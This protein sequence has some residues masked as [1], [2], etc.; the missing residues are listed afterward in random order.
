MTYGYEDP[1]IF[2]VVD[3]YDSNMI[4]MYINAARE[5]YNQNRQ[6]MKEFQ[7][8]YGDF[9]SPSTADMDY[10]DRQTRGRINDAMAYMQQ[11]GID[12][13]RSAEGRAMIQ[14]IINTTPTGE[15]AKRQQSAKVLEEYLKNKA[16]LQRANKYNDDFEQGIL[17]YREDGTPITVENW[18]TSRDG[19]WMRPS[20]NEYQDLN[21]YTGHIFDDLKDSF[22]ETKYGLDWYGV[23]RDQMAEALTPQLGGLLNNELGRFHYENARKDLQAMGVENPTDAQVM[24]QFKDNILTANRERMRLRFEENAEY[25]RQREAELEE[26][27]A[28]RNFRRQMQLA[29][30]KNSGKGS[31]RGGSRGSG[32]DGTGDPKDWR[33]SYWWNTYNGG[34]ANSASYGQLQLDRNNVPN[35]Y[36]QLGDIVPNQQMAFSHNEE[37][38]SFTDNFGKYRQHYT[39][40]TDPRE[41]YKF[42]RNNEKAELDDSG[43]FEATPDDMDRIVRD[44]YVITNTYGWGASGKMN[45]GGGTDRKRSA[46]KDGL[47][48]QGYS[49]FK[50]APLSEHYQAMDKGGRLRTYNRI[51]IYPYKRDK[52]GNIQYGKSIDAYYDMRI[53]SERGNPKKVEERTAGYAPIVPSN[54]PP[55]TTFGVADGTDILDYKQTTS[56]RDLIGTQIPIVEPITYGIYGGGNAYP[57]D[58]YLNQLRDNN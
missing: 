16:A 26:Q 31:G 13:L 35:Y 57:E 4:N 39:V 56:G 36:D 23:T 34:L 42:I 7:K 37:T 22:I 33:D 28:Q 46:L 58:T 1:A 40:L 50:V 30:A 48:K 19:V 49:G 54:E 32:S 17:G 10:V 5:Q 38:T 51:K 27:Q 6:E 44:T 24:Q 3:L 29:Q 43:K 2:P 47:K 9:Y 14:R 21:E 45:S 12:P 11:N 15:I 55:M 25:K 53:N 52:E 41:T 18:D 8:L 20:P